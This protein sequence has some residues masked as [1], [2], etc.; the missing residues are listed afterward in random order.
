[1]IRSEDVQMKFA[2]REESRSEKYCWKK[3]KYYTGKQWVLK[4]KLFNKLAGAFQVTLIVQELLLGQMAAGV[5]SS[6]WNL[7]NQMASPV[8][9]GECGCVE[10]KMLEE[11]V[12]GVQGEVRSVVKLIYAQ[13]LDFPRCLQVTR[14]PAWEDQMAEGAWGSRVEERAGF[15]WA[16]HADDLI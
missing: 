7:A 1:M 5:K 3:R 10:D 4:K 15:L 13:S 8:R 16:H 9:L 14:A 6:W 12:L 2:F 11:W